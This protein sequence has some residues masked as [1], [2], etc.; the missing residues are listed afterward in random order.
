MR[1]RRRDALKEADVIILAGAVC[2]F[3]LSYGRVLG[4]QAKVIA[5]NRNKDQLYKARWLGFLNLFL[6]I[7]LF[8]FYLY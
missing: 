7:Y 1:Q 3:R 4:R 6:F 8:I 5:V 2:D